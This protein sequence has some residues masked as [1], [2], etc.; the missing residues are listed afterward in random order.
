MLK[1]TKKIRWIFPDSEGCFHSSHLQGKVGDMSDPDTPSRSL[2]LSLHIPTALQD[3][4]QAE[5]GSRHATIRKVQGLLGTSPFDD[6]KASNLGLVSFIARWGIFPY[7]WSKLSSSDSLHE[8]T[9]HEKR[10]FLIYIIRI[11]NIAGIASFNWLTR[12]KAL[13]QRLS[14]P[15]KCPTTKH[16]C[17]NSCQPPASSVLYLITC[18]NASIFLFSSPWKMLPSE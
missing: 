4:W 1:T 14:N 2:W 8:Q 3:Y 16:S 13:H 15:A 18:G 5:D 17:H 6:E 12:L 10:T 7:Q 11:V 9:L